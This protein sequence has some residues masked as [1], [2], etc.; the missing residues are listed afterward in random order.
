MTEL[1]ISVPHSK[2]N[3]HSFKEIRVKLKNQAKCQRM[4]RNP[5]TLPLSHIAKDILDLGI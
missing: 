2:N 4:K 1:M 3:K 5:K